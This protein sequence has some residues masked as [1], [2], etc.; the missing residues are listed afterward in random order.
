MRRHYSAALLFISALSIWGC[1]GGSSASTPSPPGSP[2]PPPP[3]EVITITSNSSM[4]GVV[5]T[6]FTLTF[7]AQGNLA[8]LTWT[9]ISG[10]LPDGLLLDSQSGTISGTPAVESFTGMSIQASDG[11]ATGSQSFAILIYTKLFFT[12]APAPNPHIN[13]PYSYF[14]DPQ[15]SNPIASW[16]ITKG[17]LPPGMMLDPTVRKVI[18]G[19]PTQLGTYAFT[20][21]GQ[22]NTIPQ[23]ATQDL[24]ITVDDHVGISKPNLKPGG[25][26]VPYS[27]SFVA[28]NGTPPYHWSMPLGVL[29]NGLSMDSG[30]GHVTGT[31]TT[32]NIFTLSVTVTD[33]SSPP[34]SDTQHT[35]LEI[36][37]HLQILGSLGPAYLGRPFAGSLAST[38]GAG[39]VTWTV[40]T[41]NLPPGLNLNSTSGAVVGTPTQLG[42][43]NFTLQVASSGSPPFVVSQPF[44]LTVT[45]TPLVVGTPAS[46][47]PVNVPYHS[48]VSISGGTPPYA[49]TISSGA[50]PLGLSL[51]ASTGFI[52][53]TPTQNGTYN[54]KV[55][56]T[57]GSSPP[58]VSTNNDFMLVR[59]AFGRNDSI[60]TAT[61]VGNNL[62]GT[63]F[64]IS[65]YVD[66]VAGLTPNPDTDFYKLTAATDTTVHV[67]TVTQRFST[68]GQLDTVIEIL[69]QTGSRLN[70]CAK[71]GFTSPCLNDDL[72]SSTTDSALDIKVPGAASM[73]VPIYV[74]V[75]D[76]RGNARPD[77]TYSLQVSGV[78]E[79]L[80]I[81]TQAFPVA[82]S[83][84]NAFSYQFLVLNGVGNV[85]WS[86][87][88]GA[89]PAGWSISSGG[90]VGGTSTTSATYAFVVKVT[91]SST[92]PQIARGQYSVTIADPLSVTSP[93]TLPDACVNQFYSFKVTTTGGFAPLFVGSFS[94]SGD[95]PLYFDQTT[96][97][98]TGTAFFADTFTGVVQASD[99]AGSEQSQNVSLTVKSC[100]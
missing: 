84:G 73:N 13:V 59:A 92:P 71:P 16:A 58:Q 72:D 2:S 97:T 40:L 46:T 56:V 45:P 76:W 26:Y 81:P 55:K 24:S 33:S 54:F 93:A 25:Q 89:L 51:D 80:A 74:H 88:S 67:E 52:D 70:A 100:P 90:V 6:P 15:T 32:Y 57:D 18:T 29:P 3:A 79:P 96:Q 99:S 64:S 91:D 10:K 50:L 83:R 39:P 19:T 21:Q 68:P 5:G 94:F 66:P 27:D 38:G 34:N 48:Q 42:S 14:L 65:P 22:D 98:F 8:P 82:S 7:Q 47:A 17:Q 41:G 20:I 77:M 11:R 23:T 62:S 37:Q 4:Q 44:N 35:F 60:A 75:L 87:E 12:L 30:T 63:V 9:I 28:I 43:Y 86:L 69:D 95:W 31:T 53:G 1:G 85:T 36:D 78:A 49:W 61:P